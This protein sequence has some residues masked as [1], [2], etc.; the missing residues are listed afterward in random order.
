MFRGTFC[1][2]LQTLWGQRFAQQCL[3]K[4]VM[5]WNNNKVKLS[6]MFFIVQ[7]KVNFWRFNC[8][9]KNYEACVIQLSAL[10]RCKQPLRDKVFQAQSGRTQ[11]NRAPVSA[12]TKLQ[13][14]TI[15]IFRKGL[16]KF[17][18]DSVHNLQVHPMFSRTPNS[19]EAS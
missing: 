11:R 14:E 8:S 19:D 9:P 18:W 15:T 10:S 2:P 7:K 12:T 5:V 16:Q 3:R 1:P 6:L 4:D 17:G 13:A